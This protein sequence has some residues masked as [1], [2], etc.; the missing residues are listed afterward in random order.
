[1]KVRACATPG[2]FTIEVL[3]KGPAGEKWIQEYINF[4]G[5]FGVHGPHVFSAAPELL[6][7]LD[8]AVNLSG[9]DE[10]GKPSPWLEKATAAIAKAKG[11]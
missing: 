8:W 2:Q 10:T 11:E 7:A 4:S 6:D 9:Y 1:M 5:Y 3:P